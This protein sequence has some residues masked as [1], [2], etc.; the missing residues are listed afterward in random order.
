M[1]TFMGLD[2][3]FFF[4]ETEMGI[5]DLREKIDKL[6]D[7]ILYLLNERARL[8]QQI[9]DFKRMDGQLIFDRNRETTLLTR[10]QVLNKGPLDD[11]QIR[12]IFTAIVIACRDLQINKL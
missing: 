6:D 8:A 4:L 1:S 3:G 5:T 7:Q 11:N 12:T 10:I 9:G 2:V